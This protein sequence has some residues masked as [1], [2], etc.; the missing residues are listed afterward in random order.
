MLAA[1]IVQAATTLASCVEVAVDV[2]VLREADLDR[3]FLHLP[4][5]KLRELMEADIETAN[6]VMLFGLFPRWPILTD[7]NGDFRDIAVRQ[8]TKL[9]QLTQGLAASLMAG[10]LVG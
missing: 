5:D 2:T 9:Q 6:E 8:C 3:C 7:F 4:K 1:G 10:R